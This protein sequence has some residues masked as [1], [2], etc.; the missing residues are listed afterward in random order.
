MPPEPAA[1]TAAHAVTDA[2]DTVVSCQLLQP[3]RWRVLDDDELARARL[4]CPAR[5]RRLRDAGP[6]TVIVSIGV[7]AAEMPQEFGRVSVFDLL[8]VADHFLYVSKSREGA[9]GTTSQNER[10][11]D[12]RHPPQ[13]PLFGINSGITEISLR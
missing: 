8:R 5:S 11:T 3:W 13:Q 12:I 6:V 9:P 1:A 10:R 2:T 4:A 7:T